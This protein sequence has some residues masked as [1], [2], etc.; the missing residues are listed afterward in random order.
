MGG[1]AGRLYVPVVTMCALLRGIASECTCDVY[2]CWWADS[3]TA[4]A[5]KFRPL[6]SQKSGVRWTQ[7]TILGVLCIYVSFSIGLV[8]FA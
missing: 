2:T 5:K 8:W 1:V 7:D 3:D 4:S 6:H